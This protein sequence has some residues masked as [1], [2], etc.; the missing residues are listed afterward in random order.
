MLRMQC[1]IWMELAC[2]VPEFAWKCL[3]VAAEEE[4]VAVRQGVATEADHALLR[5]DAAMNREAV[6]EVIPDPDD[7]GLTHHEIDVD[8]WF[9][10]YYS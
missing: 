2:A 1:V 4:V 8:S 6:P 3:L 5:L 9:Y 10:S 7:P